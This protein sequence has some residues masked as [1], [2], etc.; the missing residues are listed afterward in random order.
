MPFAGY[1]NFAACVS[2]NSG[3]R[4]PQ[5]YCGAIKHAVEDKD[6]AYQEEFA[7]ALRGEDT[8]WLDVREWHNDR[9]MPAFVN[10]SLVDFE[11][12]KVT[13]EAQVLALPDHMEEG[14]LEW[15]HGR[16][17][18]DPGNEAKKGPPIKIGKPI[19]WRVKDMKVEMRWGVYDKEDMGGFGE[20]DEVEQWINQKWDVMK[21]G[22][23]V[24]MTFMPIE[25]HQEEENGHRVKVID[26]L[27]FQSVGYV[28]GL[29]ASPGAVV[30]GTSTA[31]L[32][33]ASMAGNLPALPLNPAFEIVM[34]AAEI[35]AE[36]G[37]TLKKGQSNARSELPAMAADPDEKKAAEEQAAKVKELEAKLAKAEAAKVHEKQPPEEGCPDGKVWDPDA[38]ECVDK[39]EMTEDS[40]KKE[41]ADIKKELKEVRSLQM[42]RIKE[43]LPAPEK[44]KE[45]RG[46]IA[47]AL[48]DDEGVPAETGD[49]ILAA[50]DKTVPSAVP[51]PQE[52]SFE[53]RVKDMVE[54]IVAAQVNQ[55]D[56]ARTKAYNDLETGIREK[57]HIPVSDSRVK[58]AAT[59]A[60]MG[61]S[62]ET[63][64]TGLMEKA[65]GASNKRLTGVRGGL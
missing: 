37:A 46:A 32:A 59:G 5:A 10:D 24:S 53:D 17:D 9:T 4:D 49:A 47:K 57:L 62:P 52:L 7:K 42:N 3:K 20:H 25:A 64:A 41:L 2:A 56:Q 40:L 43:G 65:R 38:G 28:R 14:F 27:H 29:A 50:F 1:A 36:E 19:G 30:T 54:G 55:M 60:G 18:K 26:R 11:G 61:L 31:K 23:T 8:A 13:L 12:D 51:T 44:L 48:E 63:A 33:E 58:P 35:E 6:G 16:D 15:M 21:K 34:K 22:G 39:E 45:L